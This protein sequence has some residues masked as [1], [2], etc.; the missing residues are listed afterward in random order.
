MQRKKVFRFIRAAIIAGLIAGLLPAAFGQT[1]TGAVD[2]NTTYQTLEGFGAAIAWMHNYLT[3]HPNKI[4]IYD[5]LFNQLGL[6]ILRLRNQYRN[7]PDF[8]FESTEIVNYANQSLGHAIKVFIA[9][10]SPPA[11]LKVNGVLNGGTLIQSNGAYVYSQFADYW[12]NSLVAYAAKGIVPTYISIQN[13]PDYQNTGWETCQFNATEGSGYPGYGT[14]LN[15]VYTRLSTMS[16]PPKI[17]GPEVTGIGSNVVQNYIAGLNLAQLYA[18]AHHLYNGGDPNNPDSFNTNMTPLATTYASLPRF[19]T[20]YDQGTAYT[21]ALLIYNAL[22][23]EQVSSYFYWDLIWDTSQRPLIA[24]ENPFTPSS[25]TTTKGYIISDF[26]YVLKQFSKFTEPGYKRIAVTSSSTD[27]R[28]T[29]FTSSDKSQT[30]IILIN[31]GTAQTTASLTLTGI[32]AGT[33]E[34]YRTIPGGTDKFASVGSLG[35][36]NSV[37]LP[38]QSITTVV[39]YA[40]GA[41]PVPSPVPLPTLV[42]PPSSRSALTTIEA[43]SYNSQSG[44][45]NELCSDTGNRDVGYIENGDWLSF[46]SLDFGTGAS[47]F[48]MHAASNTSGGNIEIRLGSTTGTLVGTCA[49]GGT[50]GWHAWTDATC[51]LT[52]VTGVNTVYLVFTGGSGYLFNLDSFTFIGGTPAPTAVPTIPPTPGPTAP[53][54]AI[55]VQYVCGDTATSVQ[56]MKPHINIVNTSTSSVSLSELTARYYYTKEGTAAEQ[57]NIDY[58]VMGSSLITDTFGSGYIEIG[59]AP[60]S[61]TLAGNGQSGEIQIRINKADW[62]NYDQSNDYSFDATKT[63]YADWDRIALYQNGT[64]IWGVPGDNST[65]AP[66]AVP[67]TPP[68]PAPTSG[69]LNGDANSSGTVDIVDA[70]LSAQYYVGLNPS[71]FNAQVADVNCSGAIDIVDALL[72]AQYYVGL[73]TSFPC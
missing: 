48:Q 19:Q 10:W 54:G 26:Y 28:M 17:I 8:D 3:E 12:Y 36:G 14:A 43:E 30:A 58:S 60:S 33:S 50:G 6:D 35:S 53:P 67:T 56:S 70:L 2:T 71:G 40:S 51:S 73:L 24:I 59:F 20:E 65:P 4:E 37:V 7:S 38:A 64:L 21:T 42:P 27:V 61:G 32:T 16:T 66:T 22:T 41:T 55:K 34:I 18:V 49:I 45:Q 57:F 44:T 68:T 5:L 46:T 13:E 23:Q 11:E 62:T 25:W 39:V 52:T 29:G 47:S 1:V 9:S 72:V 31:N 15:S 63:A 69:A